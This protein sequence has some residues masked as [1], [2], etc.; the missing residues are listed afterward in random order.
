MHFFFYKSSIATVTCTTHHHNSVSFHQSSTPPPLPFLLQL[1]LLVGNCTGTPVG[2]ETQTRT[3][4]CGG[5]IPMEGTYLWRVHTRGGY[6]LVE[7]TYSWRVHTCVPMGK[8]TT[9]AGLSVQVVDPSCGLTGSRDP[10][11]HFSI[12]YIS[13][14]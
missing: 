14:V 2:I 6:I 7:G 5:Y 10:H 4:T 9:H 8:G 1:L 12:N 3:Q 11:E 13:Q